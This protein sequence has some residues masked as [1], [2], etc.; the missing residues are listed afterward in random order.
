MLLNVKGYNRR[1]MAFP[2]FDP[3]ATPNSDGQNGN[4]DNP[5][6]REKVLEELDKETAML[7]SYWNSVT[8]YRNNRVI[9]TG[10]VIATVIMVPIGSGLNNSFGLD[11]R[12]GLSDILIP[13]VIGCVHYATNKFIGSFLE[14]MIKDITGVAD[15]LK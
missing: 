6:D 12:I 10:S 8:S 9:L 13:P 1:Y 7:R 11:Y 4:F 15:H 5:N 2:E 3:Y 14:G